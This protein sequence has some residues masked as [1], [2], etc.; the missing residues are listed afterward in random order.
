M[1]SHCGRW[2]GAADSGNF[3]SL[4]MSAGF[5]MDIQNVFPLLWDYAYG[6]NNDG[7]SDNDYDD[8]YNNN[9]YEQRQRRPQ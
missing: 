9:Y 1:R 7:S 8:H 2:G 5:E 3:V 4:N 6:N